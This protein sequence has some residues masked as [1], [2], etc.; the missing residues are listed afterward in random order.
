MKSLFLLCAPA[1]KQQPDWKRGR[2]ESGGEGPGSVTVYLPTPPPGMV[3][4]GM[5]THFE[6]GPYLIFFYLFKQ[7][8]AHTD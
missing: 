7:R 4:V 6:A 2:W 8:Y 3:K 5:Q 1:E